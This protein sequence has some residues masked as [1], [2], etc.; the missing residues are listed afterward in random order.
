[1]E[2]FSGVVEVYQATLHY[3]I[4]GTGP[5]LIL[6]PGIPGTAAIFAALVPHLSRQFKVVTYDRRG[7]SRSLISDSAA[8]ANPATIFT[9]QANDVAELIRHLSP[10]GPALIFGTSHGCL[11][12]IELLRLHPTLVRAVILHEAIIIALLR[13]SRQHAVQIDSLKILETYRR[14]GTAAA[15]RMFLPMV[16]SDA[17]REA[18]KRT[19]IHK[20]LAITA[21][22]N[23]TNIFENEFRA[24]LNFKINMELLQERKKVIY[25]ARGTESKLEFTTAPVGAMSKHLGLPVFSFA[26]GHLGYLTDEKLFAANLTELLCWKRSYL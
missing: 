18:I 23:M 15:S 12:A 19:S 5:F 9:T 20:E 21:T 14:E 11:I 25:L 22:Q 1:M 3:E 16:C 6:I 13:Q 2:N 26:G 10:G 24:I 17:D 7:F 4:S 8:E